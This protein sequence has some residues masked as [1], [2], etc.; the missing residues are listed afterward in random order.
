MEVKINNQGHSNELATTI[1]YPG[2]VQIS[3]RSSLATLDLLI[4]FSLTMVALIPRMILA[5]QLDVVTDE[6]VYIFGGKTDFHLL[7]HW[8]IR[9]SGWHYNYEHPPLVKLLIGLTLSLN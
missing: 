6:T 1:H 7:T 9:N 4:T 3:K 8:L 5:R 2:F